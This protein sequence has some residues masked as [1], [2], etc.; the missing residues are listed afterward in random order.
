MNERI[1]VVPK[2]QIQAS[3]I[4][5]DMRMIVCRD[6]SLLTLLEEQN[7]RLCFEFALKGLETQI[8]A[9]LPDKRRTRFLRDLIFLDSN[10]RREKIDMG[11]RTVMGKG[12]ETKSFSQN[13]FDDAFDPY[14]IRDLLKSRLRP[15]EGN[16]LYPIY[17]ELITSSNESSAKN[18]M[19]PKILI[20]LADHAPKM[21]KNRA[22]DV[23]EH[24][25]KMGDNEP[26][27]VVL[28][29]VRGHGMNW[30][31]NMGRDGHLSWG[32]ASDP[33][34]NKLVLIPVYNN[35]ERYFRGVGKDVV[36]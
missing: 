32:D 4:N 1:S 23:R 17:E 9:G 35:P 36:K 19:R 3:E 16:Q 12:L 24:L 30:D 34:S 25:S 14:T 13:L 31:P 15:G 20:L 6:H 29:T 33:I 22:K 5:I 28:Y 8:H 21:D 18:G 10:G 11:P 27:V 2:E 7:L 26:V